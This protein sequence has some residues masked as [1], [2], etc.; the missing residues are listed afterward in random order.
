V[1]KCIAEYSGEYFDNSDIS[2]LPEGNSALDSAYLEK[3]KKLKSRK[4]YPKK[5]EKLPGFSET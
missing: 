2:N 3:T 4:R 1:D 5:I